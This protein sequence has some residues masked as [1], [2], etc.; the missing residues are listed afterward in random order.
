M[1]LMR[2]RCLSTLHSLLGHGQQR[3]SE[4]QRLF[5]GRTVQR[6]PALGNSVLVAFAGT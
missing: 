4:L 2:L 1:T 6:F 5:T 3:N